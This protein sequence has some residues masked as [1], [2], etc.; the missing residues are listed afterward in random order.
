[1][2]AI[3]SDGSVVQPETLVASGKPSPPLD[4]S[5]EGRFILMHRQSGLWLVDG[6]G[7]KVAPFLETP[8]SEYGARISPD[9]RW[10]AYASNQAGACDVWVRPFPAS[11]APVRV[12][13]SGGHDPVWSP[14]GKELF[15]TNGPKLMSARILSESPAFKAEEARQLFEGGFK[16]DSDLVLRFFDVARDGRFLMV[17]PGQKDQARIVVAPHWDDLLK[18]HAA[19]TPGSD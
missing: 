5:P 4:W 13:S 14:D 1:V 11:G 2:L 3:A 17:E 9:G 18:K 16:Y 6:N 7:G 12:S 19:D 8:F 10:V 15:F